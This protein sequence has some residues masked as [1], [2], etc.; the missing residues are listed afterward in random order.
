MTMTKRTL[1]A[2]ILAA[3]PLATGT[4]RSDAIR[5]AGPDA[6]RSVAEH[7]PGPQWSYVLGEGLD[8]PFMWCPSMA[9]G[10]LLRML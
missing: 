9:M 3:L 6:T 8:V 1:A 7:A 4:L 5:P 2:V 10:C